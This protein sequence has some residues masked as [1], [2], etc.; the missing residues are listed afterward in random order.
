MLHTELVDFYNDKLKDTLNQPLQKSAK[1]RQN[2]FIFNESFLHDFI[3]KGRNIKQSTRF[4]E[5]VHCIST[6]YLSSCRLY[7]TVCQMPD[8]N[9]QAAN[10]LTLL[11][12]DEVESECPYL[13]LSNY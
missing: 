4:Y 5:L 13:P 3:I 9:R 7:R 8:C 10:A 1:Y 2:S 11:S 12:I 6:Q